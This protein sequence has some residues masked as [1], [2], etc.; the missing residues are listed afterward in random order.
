MKS[1]QV[2]RI[3]ALLAVI[4]A[5]GPVTGRVTAPKPHALVLHAGGR[6]VTSGAVL[7]QLAP[8]LGLDEGQ[9]R[10]FAPL[11]E[12]I[13]GEISAHPP[14][15]QERLQ[16]FRR[17]FPRMA[18]LLRPE[19]NPGFDRHV[20]DLEEKMDRL[21]RNRNRRIGA[22]NSAASLPAPATNR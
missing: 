9:Q 3:A 10:Q 12:E 14:A 5:A 16:V 6:Q 11:M 13:A 20:R 2:I 7:A 1:S 15:T 18:V 19:Q 4:F 22:T 21:I 17:Y 8:R